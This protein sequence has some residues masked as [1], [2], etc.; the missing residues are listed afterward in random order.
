MTALSSESL[1]GE[2]GT[3]GDSAGR[4]PARVTV[5]YF[6]AARQAAGVGKEPAQGATL[7]AVLDGARE[8][9]GEA[10]AAVLG[11]CRVWVNGEPADPDTLLRDG[12]EVAVLP[13]V[14]GGCR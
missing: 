2:V 12:D 13:P 8:R 14:S 7:A 4:V 6:A 11:G 10:F 3:G 5:L 1:L 9:H